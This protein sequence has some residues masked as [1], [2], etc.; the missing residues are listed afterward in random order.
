MPLL[1]VTML[2]CHMYE[3]NHDSLNQIFN[4]RNNLNSLNL[5]GN[6]QVCNELHFVGCSNCSKGC[7]PI[8]WAELCWG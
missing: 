8:K 5:H 7:S 1:S 2:T 6:L 3:K 4:V